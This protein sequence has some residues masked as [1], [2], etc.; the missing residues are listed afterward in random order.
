MRKAFPDG[1]A[2]HPGEA[3]G[4][5]R[6]LL[7]FCGLTMESERALV[8]GPRQDFARLMR[9]DFRPVDLAAPTSYAAPSLVDGYCYMG[10]SFARGMDRVFE[11]VTGQPLGE[12]MRRALA[13]LKTST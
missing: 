3:L 2:D 6:A 5:A 13:V 10:A 1:C 8:G 7:F 12:H 11:G 4:M 9:G